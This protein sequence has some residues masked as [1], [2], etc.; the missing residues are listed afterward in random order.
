MINNVTIQLPTDNGFLRRECPSCKRQFKWYTEP[1]EDRPEQ[2]VDPSSYFCP[3]CGASASSDSW[4]TPRQFEHAESHALAHVES[5][6]SKQLE[7]TVRNF[8]RKS[9]STSGLFNVSM[10]LERGRQIRKLTMQEP[11]DMNQVQSPCHPWEPIKITEDWV[12][13]IHCL[14]CGSAFAEGDGRQETS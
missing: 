2:Y 3:Y 1:T 10:K 5:E 6:A 12:G 11:S 4:H 13:E 8:N 7:R 14:F 9:Q